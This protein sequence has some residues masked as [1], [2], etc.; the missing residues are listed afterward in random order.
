MSTPIY[1][2]A[3]YV[4][5]VTRAVSKEEVCGARGDGS[6]DR[7]IGSAPRSKGLVDARNYRNLS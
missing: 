3:L 1:N 2:L 6:P 7:R 4:V 5:S